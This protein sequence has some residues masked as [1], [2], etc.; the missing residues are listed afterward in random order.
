MTEAKLDV[1]NAPADDQ[2]LSFDA[3][4]GRFEWVDQ[5]SGGTGYTDADVDARLLDRLAECAAV[6]AP[7]FFD[8]YAHVGRFQP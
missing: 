1:T 8:R 5:T 2:V 4:S 7:S 6:A 3:G